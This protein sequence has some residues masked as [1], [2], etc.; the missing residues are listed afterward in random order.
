MSNTIG[1]AGHAFE[2]AKAEAIARCRKL[3]GDDAVDSLFAQPV[4]LED[5]LKAVELESEQQKPAEGTKRAKFLKALTFFVKKV[6][7]EVLKS[8]GHLC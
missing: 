5:V 6:D 3:Y 4:T 8:D 2:D 7:A 1:A